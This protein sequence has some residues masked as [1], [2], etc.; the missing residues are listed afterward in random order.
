MTTSRSEQLT[1]RIDALAAEATA[2]QA[3][4]PAL[5]ARASE[6]CRTD[7]ERDFVDGT[8]R[9]KALVRRL[10]DLTVEQPALGLAVGRSLAL[11]HIV[12]DLL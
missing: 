9:G 7:A 1:S 10:R 3:E 2:L 12:E 6:E 11:G 8:P 4:D 5:V